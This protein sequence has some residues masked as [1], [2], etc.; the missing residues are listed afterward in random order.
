M[1]GPLNQYGPEPRARGSARE[2]TAC[3]VV[4]PPQ[5]T[6]ALRVKWKRADA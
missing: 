1:S 3:Q 4:K 5:P 6:D 2:A